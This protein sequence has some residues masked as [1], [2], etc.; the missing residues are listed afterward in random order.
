MKPNFKYSCEFLLCISAHRYAKQKCSK[1]KRSYARCDALF[2]LR[3]AVVTQTSTQAAPFRCSLGSPQLY[4]G[5]FSHLLNVSCNLTVRLKSAS[6]RCSS[7]R[8][9]VLHSRLI[10]APSYPAA[11]NACDRCSFFAATVSNSSLI[12]G[13]TKL[14]Y[15]NLQLTVVHKSLMMCCDSDLLPYSTVRLCAFQ[16]GIP[17]LCIPLERGG[18][19][20][21][22][23][24]QIPV[25]LSTLGDGIM[26]ASSCHGGVADQALKSSLLLGQSRTPLLLRIFSSFLLQD[27]LLLPS[28]PHH[29]F[30]GLLLLHMNLPVL[31]IMSLMKTLIVDCCVSRGYA[32]VG[33]VMCHEFIDSILA[34]LGSSLM[35]QSSV[36]FHVSRHS[37]RPDPSQPCKCM[38]CFQ[39]SA[40]RN[41]LL[42]F[43]T[44][45]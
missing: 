19:T 33:H 20:N 29:W 4:Q 2:Q 40:R 30:N 31:E 5:Q 15:V 8:I 14:P 32:S 35:A 38:S 12:G 45:S 23:P 13:G 9:S 27:L 22:R 34:C 37:L 1:I 42:F 3:A 24:V 39:S 43:S 7:Q 26:T 10:A 44:V 21:G 41:C 18:T 28:Y 17:A 6:V 25:P 16:R 36:H 11:L